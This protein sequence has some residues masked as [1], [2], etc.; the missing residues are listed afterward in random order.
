MRKQRFLGF[1]RKRMA[2]VAYGMS[3]RSSSSSSVLYYFVGRVILFNNAAQKDKVF[4][5]H[6]QFYCRSDIS[7]RDHRCFT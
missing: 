4:L 2:A 1:F 6:A 5:S 3:P 7:S